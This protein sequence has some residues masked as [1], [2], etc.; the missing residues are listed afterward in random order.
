MLHFTR[1]GK[2]Y[3]S[4]EVDNNVV[5][6]LHIHVCQKLLKKQNTVEKV[7]AKIKED[8]IHFAQS[9]VIS[10]QW[11]HNTAVDEQDIIT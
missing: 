3:P 2:K 1:Y 9:V 8:A 6:S 7:V 10:L 4:Q 5:V 11:M